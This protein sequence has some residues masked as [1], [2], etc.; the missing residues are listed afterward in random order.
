MRGFLRARPIK[1]RTLIT[2]DVGLVLRYLKTG[3]LSTTGRLSPKDLTFKLVLLL[4]L[5][6][7]K[8]RS[9]L[10]ALDK[11][12]RL[13][14]N[15]WNEVVLRPRP[16]FLGK[17]HFATGGAGTFSEIVLK[18]IDSA[19]GYTLPEK[20]LPGNNAACL[21]TRLTRIPQR[22]PRP[23]DYFLCER[24][25]RRHKETDDLKLP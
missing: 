9:E 15:E 16:D 3:R 12:V 18:S 2:W 24:E 7:G 21:P 11:E 20:P 19:Q 10:H 1:S 25:K 14:N 4:A 6:T 13:V 22:R 17:T 5:A 8:R 23:S